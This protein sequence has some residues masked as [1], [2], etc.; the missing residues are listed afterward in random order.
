MFESDPMSS[1]LLPRLTSNVA[2]KA[3]SSKQG[4]ALRASVDSNWVVASHLVEIQ[5]LNLAKN[6]FTGS[7]G[8]MISQLQARY[9]KRTVVPERPTGSK[10][11][12]K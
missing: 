8:K 2:F 5:N 6:I 12:I 3:G 1:F 9:S 10:N 4:K 11:R 7:M